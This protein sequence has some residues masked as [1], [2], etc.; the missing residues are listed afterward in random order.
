VVIGGNDPLMGPEYREVELS[1]LQQCCDKSRQ[2]SRTVYLLSEVHVRCALF[3]YA[4]E[5]MSRRMKET[6]NIKS[7]CNNM[8][9]THK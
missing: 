1:L 2:K 9:M 8:L 5:H 4:R 7:I 6:D 3:K